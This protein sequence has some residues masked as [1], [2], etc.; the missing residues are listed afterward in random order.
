M[1]GDLKINVSI[2]RRGES[3]DESFNSYQKACD[4]IESLELEEMEERL[5]AATDPLLL[6][7]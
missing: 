6:K 7:N 4:F 2:E 3:F 5:M 1:I